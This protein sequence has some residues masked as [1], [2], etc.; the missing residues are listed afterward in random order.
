MRI[1]PNI[2]M[3]NGFLNVYRINQD[4]NQNSYALK[5]NQQ[6][7]RKDTLSISPLGKTNSLIESLM[8]Q[9]QDII[10]RKNE[11]IGNTL[12]KGINMDSIKSQLESYE[13]QLKTID[14]QI[15]Q[16]MAEQA[17]QQAEKQKETKDAKPKTEEETE[18]E[19]L[20]SIISLSLNI[21]QA[22]VISSVKTKVD[23][24]AR[25]LKSEIELDK[26]RAGSSPSAKEFIANKDTRLTEM[27]KLSANLTVQIG[28]KLVE[29]NEE[30]KKNGNNQ[31][32]KL[33]KP[34]TTENSELIVEAN[35]YNRV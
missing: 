32:V 17:K 18:T 16:I 15:A 21:K 29:V 22:Q 25:V 1:N 2:G 6:H 4:L 26:A 23:G 27:Q 3:Q 33:E 12:E 35:Q 8:K 24:D 10:E 14:E 13:E 11:L 31:T 5:N 19:R 28:D 9:K 30:I 20:N 7:E 34:N